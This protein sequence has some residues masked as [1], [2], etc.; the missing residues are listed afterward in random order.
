[1]L[2]LVARTQRSAS[3][4]GRCRRGLSYVE[5][6]TREKAGSWLCAAALPLQRVRDTGGAYDPSSSNPHGEI[7][8]SLTIAAASLTIQ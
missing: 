1:M 2:S 6:V 3:S 4:A 5:S 8:P 7:N